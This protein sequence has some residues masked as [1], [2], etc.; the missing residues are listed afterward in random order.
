MAQQF[1]DEGFYERFP[2]KGEVERVAR[3]HRDLGRAAG[4]EAKKSLAGILPAR[5]L[6]AAHEGRTRCSLLL[7]AGCAGMDEVECRRANWYDLGF[8]DAIFGIMAQDDVYA[9]QCEPARRQGRRR[10]LSAGLA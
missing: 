1:R 9:L 10:A 7:L 5:G 8:R 2:A 3:I 4:I 6:L